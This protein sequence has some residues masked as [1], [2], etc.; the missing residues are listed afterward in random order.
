MEKVK[1]SNSMTSTKVKTIILSIVIAIVLSAFV[2]YL[3][4]SFYPRPDYNDYCGKINPPVTTSPVPDKA[5][6]IETTNQTYCEQTSGSWRNGYCDYYFK[7]QE[8]YNNASDKQKLVV[9]MVSVIAGV[10]AVALGI[11][12]QLPS[13]S[14][15]LM[16]GGAFLMFYGTAIYWTKLSNVLKTIILGAVLLILIW[17][18]YKKLKS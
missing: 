8:E 15:G 16:L 2:I 17:L 14:S 6:P 1:S 9:F 13:V 11:L 10:I 5:V 4:E 18:G 3:T 12:L 7:C